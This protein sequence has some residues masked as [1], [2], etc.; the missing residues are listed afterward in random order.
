MPGCPGEVEP[1]FEKPRTQNRKEARGASGSGEAAR[2][3][4]RP[5]PKGGTG[6]RRSQLLS[7]NVTSHRQAGRA[8]S[9][10]PGSR[11]CPD[12]ADFHRLDRPFYWEQR[13][14]LRRPQS[15][16]RKGHGQAQGDLLSPNSP[17]MSREP[18]ES[19]VA[20]PRGGFRGVEGRGFSGKLTPDGGGL[21]AAACGAGV[22]ACDWELSCPLAFEQ[23]VGPRAIPGQSL[24]F[25]K[26][27][28]KEAISRADLLSFCKQQIT[29]ENVITRSLC[30]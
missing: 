12:P 16:K 6:G 4:S 2:S 8:E 26:F 20:M 5:D 15:W 28:S 17:R 1:S 29:Q 21:E 24:C 7:Q 18:L 10:H 13:S 14:E 22:S 3:R 25:Q 9:R 23:P 11:G 27:L 19:L 30:Y